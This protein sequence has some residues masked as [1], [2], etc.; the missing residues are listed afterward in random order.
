MSHHIRIKFKQPHAIGLPLGGVLQP[1]LYA[2]TKVVNGFT[3]PVP[4]QDYDKDE[5]YKIPLLDEMP[6]ELP[7]HL[8]NVDPEIKK[9]YQASQASVA[10]ENHKLNNITRHALKKYEEDGSIEILGDS[11][12]DGTK[13]KTEDENKEW[14][15]QNHNQGNRLDPNSFDAKALRERE[16]I[17][18]HPHRPRMAVAGDAQA[19]A[20]QE[21]NDNFGG[22][23]GV[24]TTDEPLPGPKELE[25]AKKA[26][27]KGE[28]TSTE[29]HVADSKTRQDTAHKLAEK[30][31]S[32]D[33]K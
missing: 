17:E 24:P 2:Q 3:H 19:R 11:F 21:R 25:N 10:V 30:R 23:T 16:E 18:P 14:T 7:E 15:L 32:Q 31:K 22:H 4:V 33:S 12:M 8:K 26:R 29:N 6:P 20:T 5:E 27:D 28:V 9:A 1:S 13:D